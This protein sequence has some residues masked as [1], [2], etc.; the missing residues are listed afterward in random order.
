MSM[1][2]IQKNKDNPYVILNKGF[3]NNPK[4][5][6]KAKGLLAYLLSLPDDWQI[7]ENELVKHF[8][9]GRD[10]LRSGIQE[11]VKEG[12]IER[13]RMRNDD[14]TLGAYEYSVYE[15]LNHI[16]KSNIGKSNIG[17]SNIGKSNIGKSNTTNNKKINNKKTNKKITNN[18][19]E[20]PDGKKNNF[21]NFE[22]R[23]YDFDALEKKLL[24]WGEEEE[25]K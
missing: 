18:T 15:D 13:V 16:G 4:L 19:P 8:K 20:K 2:R 10:S 9:D 25:K 11:L 24:G 6:A 22:Q 7:Y 1:F 3:L 12:Y 14:G 5:S 21:N 23:T 17:E